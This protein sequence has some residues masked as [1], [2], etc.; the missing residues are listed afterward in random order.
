MSTMGLMVTECP[1][2]YWKEDGIVIYK[3]DCREILP[4]LNEIDLVLT[5]PPYGVNLGA[6]KP[7]SDIKRQRQR[8][9][10]VDDTPEFV[11]SMVVPVVMNCIERFKR[12]VVMPGNRCAWLHPPPTCHILFST[13]AKTRRCPTL[14]RTGEYPRLP[15]R[16]TGIPVQSRLSGCHG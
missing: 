6:K 15:Q 9:L 1:N 2:P 11:A 16:T 12:V 7:N 10:S 8:Y 13:T 5:D 4:L 14:T 3:G